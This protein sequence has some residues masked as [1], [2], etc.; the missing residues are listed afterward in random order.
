MLL[1]HTFPIREQDEAI[2]IADFITAFERVLSQ[3]CFYSRI[4]GHN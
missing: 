2:R 1:R 3:F 4:A